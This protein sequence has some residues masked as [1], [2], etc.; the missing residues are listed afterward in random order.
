LV[1][2]AKVPSS[3]NLTIKFEL[4]ER[5]ERISYVI[6]QYYLSCVWAMTIDAAYSRP[7]TAVHAWSEDASEDEIRATE[8]YVTGKNWT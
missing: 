7:A 1:L 5:G 8:N 6:V 3:V 4:Y 2:S